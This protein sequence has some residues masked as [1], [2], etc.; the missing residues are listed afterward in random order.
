[1]QSQKVLDTLII[2]FTQSVGRRGVEFG[3]QVI[4]QGIPGHGESVTWLV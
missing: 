2:V 4:F 3:P 1:M